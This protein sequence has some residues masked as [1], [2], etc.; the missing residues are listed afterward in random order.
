MRNYEKELSNRIANLEMELSKYEITDG[1]NLIYDLVREK[2]LDKDPRYVDGMNKIMND[3]VRYINLTGQLKA[4]VWQK[5]D[6]IEQVRATKI[7]KYL[8]SKCKEKETF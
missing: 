3:N 5:N 6:M 2:G 4:K 7:G 8:L 1:M